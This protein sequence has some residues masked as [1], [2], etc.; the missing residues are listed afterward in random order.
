MALSGLIQR[1]NSK[2]S[3]RD[4]LCSLGA[5]AV[6]QRAKMLTKSRNYME[7]TSSPV[8]PEPPRK[9]SM[10]PDKSTPYYRTLCAMDDKALAQLSA[11]CDVAYYVLRVRYS[12]LIR[13]AEKSHYQDEIYKDYLEDRLQRRLSSYK[14]VNGVK[15]GS[16]LKS[17]CSCIARDYAKSARRRTSVPVAAAEQ[18]TIFEEFAETNLPIGLQ[19]ICQQLRAGVI[20]RAQLFKVYGERVARAMLTEI[21]EAHFA[22]EE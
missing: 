11:N 1:T 8:S 14:P 19:P 2:S 12:G 21:G 7:T 18:I 6:P 20:N 15:L 10:P 5:S 22:E 4:I 13:N 9:E 16:W 17:A 3:K